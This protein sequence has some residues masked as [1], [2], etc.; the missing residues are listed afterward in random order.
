MNFRIAKIEDLPL[1]VDIYNSTVASRMVT[2]DTEPVTV[3]S[4]KEWFRRHNNRR[5]LF[6]AENDDAETIGW[7]SFQDFYGRPAY[8][9][10]A[11]IS[12]YLDEKYRGRGYGH[13]VLKFAIEKATSLGIENLLGFIFA[14]NKA[15]IKLFM[16]NGFSR[17]GHLPGVAVLDGRYSDLEILG[18]KLTSNVNKS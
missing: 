5:P 18:L 7:L 4:K 12:I 13:S 3:A 11:E 16:N 1:I 14:Q 2:A 10:T 6:I 17:W 8:G 9:I 15:S